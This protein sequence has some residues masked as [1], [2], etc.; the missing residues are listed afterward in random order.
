VEVE[1]R[2]RLATLFTDV[3]YHPVS[4]LDAFEARYLGCGQNEC[5]CQVSIF[6]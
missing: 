2:H 4:I 1:V 3:R 5:A 6:L